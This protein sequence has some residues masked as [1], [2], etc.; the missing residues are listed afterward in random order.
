M[1]KWLAVVTVVKIKEKE[2][3]INDCRQTQRVEVW[4]WCAEMTEGRNVDIGAQ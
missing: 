4:N 2:L 1:K 3:L